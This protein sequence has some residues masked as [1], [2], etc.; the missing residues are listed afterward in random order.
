MSSISIFPVWLRAVQG[1][2][3]TVIDSLPSSS[4]ALREGPQFLR[5]R[6]LSDAAASY[7]EIGTASQTGLREHGCS[8]QYVHQGQSPDGPWQDSQVVVGAVLR[9]SQQ[10]VE[11]EAR[12]VYLSRGKLR[13][14]ASALALEQVRKTSE[15]WVCAMLSFLFGC[16]S[17][18]VGQG[19]WMDGVGMAF[20]EGRSRQSKM[21]TDIP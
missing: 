10:D 6:G 19:R 8:V 4:A 5:P 16:S 7:A 13:H 11:G 14:L 1:A 17:V 2:T 3:A 12:F 18:T 9:G 15:S 21:Q 20:A